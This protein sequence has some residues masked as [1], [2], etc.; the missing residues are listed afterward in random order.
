[1]TLNSTDVTANY[2]LGVVSLLG[3]GEERDITQAVKY[4]ENAQNEASALNALGVI[5]Y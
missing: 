3:L 4:F 2:W 1:L 5:Y